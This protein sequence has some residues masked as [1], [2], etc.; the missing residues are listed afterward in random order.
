LV[1]LLAAAAVAAC[2]GAVPAPKATPAS[3]WDAG[4]GEGRQRLSPCHVDGVAEEVLCGTVEVWE[5]REAQRG[6]RLGLKVVVL[7]ALGPEPAPDPIFFFAGGP[8]GAATQRA[9]YFSH[10]PDLRQARDI[11]L[12]DQ[13]GTGGSNPLRCDFATSSEPEDGR[14]P[15]LFPAAAVE[16]CRQQL[17]QRAD[18]TLYTS[19]PAVDDYD[20]VRR[21][22]GYE[23]INLVGGSYGSR[24]AQL[25]LQR[26]PETVRAVALRAVM[27]LEHSA[28]ADQAANAQHTLEA[29]FTACADEAACAAAFPELAARFAALLDSLTEPRRVAIT[30]PL[31]GE[32]RTL[33]VSRDRLVE[34]LRTLLYDL[35]SAHALPF[36]LHRAAGG[37]LA[38]FAHLMA[39]DDRGWGQL[40]T[41]MLLSVYCGEDLP[42]FD[43][44]AALK[45][46]EATVFGAYRLRQQVEACAQWP[47]PPKP[48]SPFPPL[49]VDTPVLLVSGELDPVNP[50]RYGEQIVARL[51]AGRHLVLPGA[52]H[53]LAG[54]TNP[55][56]ALDLEAAFLARGTA[57]GL[58]LSCLETVRPLPFLTDEAAFE[59]LVEQWAAWLQR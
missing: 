21:R 9:V 15:E 7:P 4:A 46:A 41:G 33:V 40:A 35:D 57:E 13:R 26:H 50:A 2:G 16:A 51:P 48:V 27:P 34:S 10:R 45:R 42:T 37:D 52:H 5:D 49:A 59:A 30:D 39:L 17:S 47:Q 11:V 23:R 8:G 55:R 3:G 18:L 29:L 14:L 43:V 6:R 58:D 32:A 20:E 28:L 56:C 22:L 44:D 24:T 54:L 19:T 53:G 31:T 36:A 25:Y 12:I 38:P 1:L